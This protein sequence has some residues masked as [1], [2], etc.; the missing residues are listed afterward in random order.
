MT[1]MKKIAMIGAVLLIISS[2]SVTAYAASDYKSP[3]EAAAGIT[4]KTIEEVTGERQ[5]NGKTYGE[6]ANEAGKLDEFRNQMLEMKKSTLAQKVADGKLT[7]E[8]A[9]EILKAIE[10]HSA[11]CDGSEQARMGLNQGAGFGMKNGD[12]ENENCEN[13]TCTGEK[14]GNCEN[15]T[16]TGNEDS[17]YGFNGQKNMEN[18]P[19]Q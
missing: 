1:K 19:N 7:Q 3:A 18:C 13:G 10:E 11:N 5:N 2:V 4:G 9:D 8:R 17:G 12:C 15:G 6:I 16:C 14:S